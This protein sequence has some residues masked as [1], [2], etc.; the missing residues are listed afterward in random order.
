LQQALLDGY[1]QRVI[2][3]RAGKLKTQF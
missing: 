1:S 2:W 3:R